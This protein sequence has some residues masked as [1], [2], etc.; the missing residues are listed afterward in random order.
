MLVGISACV[1]A[2]TTI[3]CMIEGRLDFRTIVLSPLAG[4]VVISTSAA[5]CNSICGTILIG[6]G[7]AIALTLLIRV[8]RSLKNI[9]YTDNNAFLLF[10]LMGLAGGLISTIFVQI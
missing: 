6:M 5:I 2:T 8:P 4:G 1:M 10:G 3:E 7:T 9:L